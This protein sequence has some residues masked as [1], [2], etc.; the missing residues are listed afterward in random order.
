MGAREERMWIQA[1]LGHGEQNC[2]LVLTMYLLSEVAWVV[3]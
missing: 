3:V 1:D 2:C